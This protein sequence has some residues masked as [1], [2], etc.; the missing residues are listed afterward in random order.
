MRASPVRSLVA[1]GVFSVVA[2][3]SN[4]FSSDDGTRIRLRNSS[5]FE[6]TDVTFAPG[7]PRLEFDR[8]GPGEVTEYRSADGAYSYGYLD[9]LVGGE[10]RTL[11]PI[12]YVGE[13][14][15]DD[16]E[17]TFVITI[18]ATTRYPAM[19]VRKD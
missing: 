4:P 8:I 3:C 16:G 10:R 14:P 7:T 5:S 11:Q 17:Y 6:L 12:D 2:A 19:Q 15:L 9:V 1:A 13:E 18:D